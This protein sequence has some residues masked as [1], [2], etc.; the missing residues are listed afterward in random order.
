MSS[1]IAVND[2]SGKLQN[3]ERTIDEQERKNNRI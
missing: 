1:D 3:L 2:L